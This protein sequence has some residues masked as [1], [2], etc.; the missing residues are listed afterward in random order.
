MRVKE[1]ALKKKLTL[2]TITVPLMVMLLNIKTYAATTI[3]TQEV[4]TATQNIR[5][6]VI[7][8]AMPVGS[9]LMFVSIVIIAIKLIVN[10]NN[11]NKRSEGIG[12]LAWV[13]GG[14]ML[15]SLALIVSGI[16]LS[17]A[18][19]GSGAMVGGGGTV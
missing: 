5:D 13:A 11:P 17:V 9:V 4:E 19:N 8:L 3:G 12:G 15:L 14:F 2:S 16:V 7:K 18:T 1:K 6:A 10:A